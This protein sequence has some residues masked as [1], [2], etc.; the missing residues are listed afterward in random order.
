MKHMKFLR[1][2]GA[3]TLAAVLM[4][5]AAVP[6][7]ATGGGEG[8]SGE[9]TLLDKKTVDSG[10]GGSYDMTIKNVHHGAEY[11]M[12]KLLA[13]KVDP[14]TAGTDVKSW[15]YTYDTSNTTLKGVVETVVTKDE[16]KYGATYNGSVNSMGFEVNESFLVFQA[17]E[18]IKTDPALK[19]KANTMMFKFADEMRKGIEGA[20]L[21]ADV[22]FNAS[23]VKTGGK[24]TVENLQPGYWMVLSNAGMRSV[25]FTNPSN[26]NGDMT[27]VEKNDVPTLQKTANVSNAAIGDQVTYTITSTAGAGTENLVVVDKM[28]KGLRFD[29]INSVKFTPNGSTS[30][31]TIDKSTSDTFAGAAEAT[32]YLLE[33]AA[34]DGEVNGFSLTINPKFLTGDTFKGNSEK[35]TDDGGTFEVVYFATITGAALNVDNVTNKAYLRYGHDANNLID[36]SKNGDE[37]TYPGYVID[38]YDTYTVKWVDEHDSLITDINPNPVTINYGDPFPANPQ[39]LGVI[40][41][42]GNPSEPDASNVITIKWV[43]GNKPS[44]TTDGT[45]YTVKWVDENN[46]SIPGIDT[47]PYTP[48]AAFPDN[49]ADLNENGYWGD[50]SEPD[51]SNVIT[52]KWVIREYPG[53]GDETSESEVKINL[54]Y[55][56]LN[57]HVLGDT[58]ARLPGAEFY[59]FRKPVGDLTPADGVMTVGNTEYNSLKGWATTADPESKSDP[60]NGHSDIPFYG[61]GMI[62]FVKENVDAD[63]NQVYRP[64]VVYESDGTTLT[65]E[66]KNAERFVKVPEGGNIVIKGLNS[67]L[68]AFTEKTAPKGYNLVE[69]PSY[70]LVAGEGT[71]NKVYVQADNATGADLYKFHQLTVGSAP[72]R[73]V[74][75]GHASGMVMPE[76]GGIGTTIFYI[77]GAAFVAAAGVLLILK[78]RNRA[79]GQ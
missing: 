52:V 60:E 30:A 21:T 75:I 70:A 77:A 24:I 15:T 5:A 37:A 40:G 66:F 36:T 19:E 6:A 68:Y 20:T 48:P 9:V 25:I 27:V 74:N 53:S 51:A 65:G 17:P 47:K 50:P 7:F 46:N 56:E 49:P 79:D 71:D 45:T 55:I 62:R 10:K 33:D 58:A 38:P 63:G 57:S 42:W 41:H 69:S 35:L 22:T 59:A 14:D 34:V 61:E 28:S 32:Y 67:S 26:K 44:S 64:A 43:P 12:Y 39:R 13:L 2:L 16:F 54:H 4:M 76:T 3:I 73:I 18:G 72:S 29:K 31:T 78:K 11:K 1:K 8:G 23:D